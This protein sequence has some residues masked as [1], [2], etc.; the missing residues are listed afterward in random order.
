MDDAHMV[1]KP[2]FHSICKQVKRLYDDKGNT[3]DWISTQRHMQK[4]FGWM[5]VFFM[6]CLFKDEEKQK[7]LIYHFDTDETRMMVDVEGQREDGDETPPRQIHPGSIAQFLYKSV[8]DI[9]KIIRIMT[10]RPIQH[11][12]HTSH[13]WY[14]I[15]HDNI[16][17]FM[18]WWHTT[19]SRV[20]L[21]LLVRLAATHGARSILHFLLSRTDC[22]RQVPHWRDVHVNTCLFEN[23]LVQ[24]DNDSELEVITDEIADEMADE[25]SPTYETMA[26]RVLFDERHYS[27]LDFFLCLGYR[28]H[29]WHYGANH[30]WRPCDENTNS[31][32]MFRIMT[33]IIENNITIFHQIIDMVPVIVSL[34][35]NRQLYRHMKKCVVARLVHSLD[36]IV[37]T[38][39]MFNDRSI[40]DKFLRVVAESNLDEEELDYVFAE[41]AYIRD[42][43]GEKYWK[44]VV[45]I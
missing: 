42:W 20:S 22:T 15:R 31:E 10:H 35:K 5:G 38:A 40:V 14:I 39:K 33:Y 43:I 3:E 18:R 17:E 32:A 7:D 44:K 30:A 21:Y 11:P 9:A 28:M 41:R 19:H 6:A 37:A 24:R 34:R 16:V 23:Y 25:D 2:S 45:S 13:L 12:L 1:L 4:T 26:L 29:E 36:Y 27:C 8:E